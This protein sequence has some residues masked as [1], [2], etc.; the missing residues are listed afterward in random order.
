MINFHYFDERKGSTWWRSAVSY[1]SPDI[2]S[3]RRHRPHS[4]GD[5]SVSD[6]DYDDDNDDDDVTTMM[7]F[8]RI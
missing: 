4:N 8:R 1:T 5:E 3:A 6:D 2:G 7:I